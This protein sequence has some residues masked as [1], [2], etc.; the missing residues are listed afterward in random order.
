MGRDFPRGVLAVYLIDTNAISALS[1]AV[2]LPEAAVTAWLEEWSADLFLSVVTIAE[3]EDGIA[4][5][6]R[7]G[8]V[9]KAKDIAGW[10][11][12][13]LHLYGSRILAVDLATARTAGALSDRARGLGRAPGLADILIASTA[14]RN[15]L[16]VVTRKTMDFEPLEV[17]VFDPWSQL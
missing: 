3:I 14:K 4:K 9:R 16:T 17:P 15:G 2:R 10:L 5:L 7:E 12:S 1:P 8:A 13:V 6:R 11:E